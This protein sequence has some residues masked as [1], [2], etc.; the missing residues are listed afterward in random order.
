MEQITVRDIEELSKT[1]AQPC[2]SIFLPIN[3]SGY[4]AY[5]G[6]S[7]INF[8]TELQDIKNKMI[9]KGYQEKYVERFFKE[10]YHL[11]DG[12]D[13]WHNPGKGLAVFISEGYFKAGIYPIPFTKR[14]FLATEFMITPLMPLLNGNGS[15]GLQKHYTEVVKVQLEKY[16]ELSGTGK[17]SFQ[18]EDIFLSAIEGRVESFFYEKGSHMWATISQNN[19]III[20]DKQ[21][22]QDI[23]L[24]N[25]AAINSILN[26]GIA[27]EIEKEEIPE[28]QFKTPVAAVYRY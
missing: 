23:C 27:A 2:V 22:D 6:N 14:H 16:K 28:K 17:T 4:Q 10:T 3:S 7:Q 18:V 25:A 21:E 9:A 15:G 13:I 11:L 1:K 5:G 19:E 12:N 20:H 8:K 26:N 24:I